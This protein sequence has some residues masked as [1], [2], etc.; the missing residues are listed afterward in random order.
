VPDPATGLSLRHVFREDALGEFLRAEDP[1]TGEGRCVRRLHA[2]LVDDESAR[3]LF[4]E[5]VRRIATLSH[6]SLLRVRRNDRDAARPFL[7]TDPI[8]EGTLEDDV[9]TS[10]PWDAAR[11]RRFV[12]DLLGGL[13]QLED[14]RQVHVALV[15]S[16]FVR[17]GTDFRLT[18]FRDVRAEDETLRLKGREVPD[19]RFAAPELAVGT[20]APAKARPLTA[21]AVGALWRWLRTGRAP[22]DGPIPGLDG[23]D[24][25][26]IERLL[27]DEPSLR[28]SG[29]AHLRG[30]LLADGA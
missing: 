25:V 11:A 6:P 29:A 19:P 30:L 7:V 5:E 17:V 15:P 20:S 16:R 21:F 18:T 9:R 12:T 10:G 28:P 23:P 8:D 22:K 2:A 1:A 27:E 26:W 3:L 4:A 14:R 24:G 13:A